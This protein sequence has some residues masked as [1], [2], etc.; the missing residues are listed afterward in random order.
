MTH[1][2]YF[3]LIFLCGSIPFGLI[4]GLLRGV[5]IRKTGSGN[6]G[7]TN[8]SRVFGFWGGFVP[9]TLL[10]AA[11]GY[12][13][14]L[15]YKTM[16]QPGDLLLVIAAFAAILGHVFSP[17]LGFRGG[18][19][20]AT[21]AGTFLFLAPVPAFIA[22]CIWTVSF[23]VLGKVVGRAS[24][25]AAICFPFILWLVPDTSWVLRWLS[26]LLT[27]LIIYAHRSNLKKWIN[28]DDA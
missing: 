15:V 12:L 1:I 28:K 10:D 11:K 20:V 5:D 22:I 25:I 13:P 3:A 23:F 9:I 8:V 2:I 26:L 6:I 4:Y 18:K 27:A 21:S 14:L 19:G 16:M 24:I 17:W 7:A